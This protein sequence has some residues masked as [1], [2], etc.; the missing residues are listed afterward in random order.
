MK[1]SDTENLGNYELKQHKPWFV[2]GCSKLLD[3][4][5]QL[6][7]NGC[8]IQ[9]KHGDNMNSVIS[10]TDRTFRKKEREYLKEKK[11]M[12]LTQTVRKKYQRLI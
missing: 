5:K 3:K 6:N 2:E 7:C 10:E 8:R 1:A 9:V 4:R 12:S 11:L